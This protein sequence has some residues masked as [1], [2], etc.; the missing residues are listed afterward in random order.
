MMLHYFISP[1][2]IKDIVS[3]VRC[4]TKKVPPSAGEAINV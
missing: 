4:L 2:N 1:V 3:A